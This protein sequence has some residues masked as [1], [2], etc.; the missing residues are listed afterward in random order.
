MFFN[1][2]LNITCLLKKYTFHVYVPVL[3]SFMQAI[4]STTK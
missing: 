3:Y 1:N 2:S 4:L